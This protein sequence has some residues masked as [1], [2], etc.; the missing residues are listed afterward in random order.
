MRHGPQ[1]RPIPAIDSSDA[2]SS[3]APRYSPPSLVPA[4]RSRA[5]DALSLV[6]KL[7]HVSVIVADAE[8][9]RAFYRDVFGLAEIARPELGYPGAW[10]QLGEQQFHLLQLPAPGGDG[11]GAAHVGRDRHIAVLVEDLGLLAERLQAA[12]VEFTR[13]RSGRAA[14]FC[15]DPDGNGIEC[16]EASAVAGG[17]HPGHPQE[18]V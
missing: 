2:N 15:R 5:G 13:S 4:R 17:V 1:S 12:R 7:H 18:V 14:L 9:S 6:L 16:I 8:R 11:T 10:L 3:D